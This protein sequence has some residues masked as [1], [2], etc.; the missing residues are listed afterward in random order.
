M[1]CFVAFAVEESGLFIVTTGRLPAVNSPRP[2]S[3]T[4]QVPQALMSFWHS[5]QAAL[6]SV[7]ITM[8]KLGNLLFVW[9]VGPVKRGLL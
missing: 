1:Q 8:R 4:W 5:S 9:F 2:A 3:S 6:S 7:Q